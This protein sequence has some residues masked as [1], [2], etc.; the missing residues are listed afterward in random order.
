MTVRLLTVAVVFGGF[1]LG[2][3]EVA[4]ASGDGAVGDHH[5]A[6]A[7]GAAKSDVNLSRI[8]LAGANAQPL[9]VDPAS[10]SPVTFNAG[11]GSG[12]TSGAPSSSASPGMSGC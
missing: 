2:T 6:R 3:P 12:G 5:L 1:T 10:E 9:A 7:S 4:G 11:G 8:Q